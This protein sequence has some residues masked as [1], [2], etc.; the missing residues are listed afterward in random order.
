M[1]CPPERYA[2]LP[3]APHY[4][5]G[6]IKFCN[7]PNNDAACTQ[8]CNSSDEEIVAEIEQIE[9]QLKEWQDKGIPD[10]VRNA[11]PELA[12]E[13][14][15]PNESTEGG[16]AALAP[17]AAAAP[18]N[19]NIPPGQ[20]ADVPMPMDVPLSSNSSTAS[21]RDGGFVEAPRYGLGGFVKD[22]VGSV[23]NAVG[24]NSGVLGAVIGGA[25]AY[26]TGGMSVLAGASLGSAAGTYAGTGDLGAAA[27]AGLSTYGLG[28]AGMGIAG[29]TTK[30]M[31]GGATVAGGLLGGSEPPPSTLQPMPTPQSNPHSGEVSIPG[32]AE[33][34]GS[35]PQLTQGL[36]QLPTLSTNLDAFG[37][38]DPMTDMSLTSGPA[39]SLAVDPMDSYYQCVIANG[40]ENCQMPEYGTASAEPT[41][42]N[43]VNLQTAQYPTNYQGGGAV[44]AIGTETSDSQPAW[45]SDNEFVLTAD[46]VRGMGDGNIDV[47]AGRLYDLQAELEQRGH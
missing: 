10:E 4:K 26:Y 35:N 7:D 30:G 36:G 14:A 9:G 27:G 22:T 33:R 28:A 1:A 34:I 46:A 11:S 20:L 19:P 41:Q 42:Q 40:A 39:D 18:I 47:G 17:E 37:D 25:M 5:E 6:L 38:N 8:L 21:Y 24:G 15:P 3:I 31:V 2:N 44:D 23:K 32:S 13:L 43:P 45:L 12:N 29:G 16:I